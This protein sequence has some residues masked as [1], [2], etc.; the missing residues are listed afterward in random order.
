MGG[1]PRGRETEREGGERVEGR[2]EAR[3]GNIGRGN[4]PGYKPYIYIYIE[5]GLI[6]LSYTV[7]CD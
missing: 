1:R 4:W 2:D 5:R 3:N 6:A 7:G